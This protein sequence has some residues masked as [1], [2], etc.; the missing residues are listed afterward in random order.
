MKNV[1]NIEFNNL[2]IISTTTINQH[3]K[4]STTM[5]NIFKQLYKSRC[6]NFITNNLTLIMDSVWV[7]SNNFGQN[8]TSDDVWALKSRYIKKQNS[9]LPPGLIKATTRSV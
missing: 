5:L 4:S 8:S 6:S 2:N 1:K 3:T 7:N 9:R